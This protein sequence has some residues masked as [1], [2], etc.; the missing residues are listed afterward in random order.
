MREIKFRSKRADN[1]EWVYGYLFVNQSGAHYILDTNN[2]GDN[3]ITCRF[4]LVDPVTVGQ[5]TG[6]HDKNGAE[7]YEDDIV[8]CRHSDIDQIG[9]VYFDNEKCGFYFDEGNCVSP[10]SNWLKHYS[11]EVIG[12]IHD[13]PTLA[14]GGDER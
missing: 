11:L 7:I 6:L 2:D 9:K 3:G 10:V 5:F 14:Q 8:S 1:G 13:T 4:T 12:S